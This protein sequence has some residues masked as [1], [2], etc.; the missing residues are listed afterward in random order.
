MAGIGAVRHD[1]GQRGLVAYVQTQRP[2]EDTAWQR[3]LPGGPVA[4]LPCRDGRSSIVWTLPDAEAARLVAVDVGTFCRE[5]TRACDAALGDVV[6]VSARAVFPLR[7]Q[8]AKRFVDGRIALCGDAAHVVHPLAGQG[9]NI[10]LRDVIALRAMVVSATGRRADIGAPQRLE[11]WQR[12]R[13]SESTTAAWTF[14]GINR[15]FSNDAP[16]ATLARGHLLDLAG[17]IPGLD[18]RLWKRAAGL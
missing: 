14:D 15:L 8:I 2:H 10:G 16:L 5:L 3:F 7:R 1:Y 4:F 13:R 17:R 9:L 6:G 12:E 11:R 18:V